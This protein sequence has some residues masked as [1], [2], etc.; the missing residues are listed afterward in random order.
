MYVMRVVVAFT[1][2]Y[3]RYTHNKTVVVQHQ[4]A[5]TKRSELTVLECIASC[6]TF[7]PLFSLFHTLFSLR[8]SLDGSWP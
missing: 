8:S 5:K 3:E 7:V 6:L 4:S 2:I 1:N